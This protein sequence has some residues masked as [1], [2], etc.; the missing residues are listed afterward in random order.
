MKW[1]LIYNEDNPEEFRHLIPCES[2]T[3]ASK[4]AGKYL[5]KDVTWKIKFVPNALIDFMKRAMHW[6]R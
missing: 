2:W 4:Y 1:Y 5:R 6:D 3:A